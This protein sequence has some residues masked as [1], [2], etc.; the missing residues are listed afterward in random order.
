MLKFRW[1]RDK[2]VGSRVGR[3]PTMCYNAVRGGTSSH[4]A[5]VANDASTKKG[6][7]GPMIFPESATVSLF[8][9]WARTWVVPVMLLVGAPVAGQTPDMRL[10]KKL[11]A[12]GW[13][14]PR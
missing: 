3:S 13:D 6:Q 1:F 11:I 8:A 7:D 9:H 5:I 12:T 14:H 4:P 2:T 10:P